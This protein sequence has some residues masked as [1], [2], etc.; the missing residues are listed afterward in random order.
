MF[1]RVRKIPYPCTA[2]SHRFLLATPSIVHSTRRLHEWTTFY[3]R[4]IHF[5]ITTVPILFFF[6]VAIFNSSS[7]IKFRAQP[8]WLNQCEVQSKTSHKKNSN[9]R[10]ATQ[11][12][13]A[14]RARLPVSTNDRLIRHKASGNRRFCMWWWVN[15]EGTIFSTNKIEI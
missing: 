7:Q 4:F 3:S 2:S 1:Q 9:A 10:M 15:Y 14:H 6:V 13:I 5:C 12:D 11:N 8:K